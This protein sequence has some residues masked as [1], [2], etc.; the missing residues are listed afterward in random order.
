MIN[1]L[2]ADFRI[3]FFEMPGDSLT[4]Q[5]NIAIHLESG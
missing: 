3:V 2:A 5:G 1:Q 4:E